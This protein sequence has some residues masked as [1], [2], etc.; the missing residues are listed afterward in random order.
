MLCLE[1]AAVAGHHSHL[2]QLASA[3]GRDVK[4]MDISEAIAQRDKTCYEE[5]LA[6]TLSRLLRYVSSRQNHISLISWDDGCEKYRA[7]VDIWV[8]LC[9]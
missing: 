3:G 2:H 5:H 6:Q 8:L 1:A 7:F 4:W 9:T